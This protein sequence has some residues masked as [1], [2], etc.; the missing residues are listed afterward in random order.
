[1]NDIIQTSENRPRRGIFG[2]DFDNLF[3]GFFRPLSRTF[4][5]NN[6]SMMPAVDVVDEEARYV[7]KAELPGVSK[8]DIDVAINDGILT[9]NAERK[10]E[11]EEKDEKGR[12][13]RRESHYGNYVRSMRLDATIDVKKVKASYKDGILKL[14]LP[15]TEQ[16][17]PKKIEIDIN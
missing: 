2:D 16:A 7:V 15:K 11:D 1:M 14:E 5:E 10:I 4:D 9:I 3:E 17:K 12:V 8:K 13:I 6:G